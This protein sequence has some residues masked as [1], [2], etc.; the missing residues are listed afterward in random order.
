[1]AL[2]DFYEVAVAADLPEATRLAKTIQTCSPEILVPLTERVTNAR[3]EGFNR[4]I[5]QVKEA[6][7]G[8]RN[9]INFQRRIL[10]ASRSLDR[11]DQQREQ[12]TP[13]SNS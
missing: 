11:K 2:A 10:T 13:R 7:C 3:T 4:I 12:V 5:K 8:Y 1:M 6:G 9:M